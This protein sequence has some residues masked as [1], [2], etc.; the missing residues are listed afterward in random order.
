MMNFKLD[1]IHHIFHQ[2]I[3]PFPFFFF[4]F[5]AIFP[6][7]VLTDREY[8]YI[9]LILFIR[10]M[11]L[12][13]ISLLEL[14]WMFVRSASSELILS[15]TVSLSFSFL[16]FFFFVERCVRCGF[17]NWFK[18]P[19]NEWWKCVV[20]INRNS[21][22]LKR[23]LGRW[24]GIYPWWTIF[25]SVATVLFSI[26]GLFFWTEENDGI[27]LWTTYDS[28]TRFNSRWVKDHFSDVRYEALIISADNILRP[29]V[30]VTVNSISQMFIFLI[31][32]ASLLRLCSPIPPV[33]D[34][35]LWGQ[36]QWGFFPERDSSTLAMTINAIV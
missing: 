33:L 29:D 36:F 21:L 31:S 4:R 27:K 3:A 28:P 1:W 9:W 30:L 10:A 35:F 13:E 5:F 8:F 15:E 14:G 11:E 16:F 23:R 25:V 34:F 17:E 24:I 26:G 7:G 19:W 6:E 32:L 20:E 18:K 12:G 22:G 2:L